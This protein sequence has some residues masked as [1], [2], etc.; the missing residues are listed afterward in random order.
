MS[1]FWQLPRERLVAQP[2]PLH[3]A[4]RLSAEVGRDIWLKRDDLTGRGLGGNKLRGLEY[5]L[6]DAVAR[7]C[8]C[9]VTGGGPQS[10]WAMLAATAARTRGLDAHLAFYGSPPVEDRG[11]LLLDRLVGASIEFTGDPARESV[12]D[13]VARRAATL[14][15]RGRRPYVIP[16]GGATEVGALGYVR[17]GVELFGQLDAVSVAAD[18]VWLATG[19]CATQAGLAFAR[20]W[21]DAPAAIRGV[22]VSRAQEECVQR[23]ATLTAEMGELTGLPGQVAASEVDVR[24]GYEGPGYGLASPEGERAAALVARLE[25]VFLDP[26][27]GAK[28]MAALLDDTRAAGPAVFLVSGGAPTL[29]AGLGAQL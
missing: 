27:F 9:V 2:T 23:V 10:N 14:E 5:L 1:A 16:R 19:S 20:A 18:A 29:F 15:A 12:D 17:G 11:N 13:A 8:D 24:K 4:E 26:V 28:A 6:G 3:R 25:G 7:G 21:L 22:T